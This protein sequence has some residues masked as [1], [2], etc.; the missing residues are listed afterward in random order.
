[1][2][3]L[4]RKIGV[5]SRYFV[6]NTQYTH[7][8]RC[9]CKILALPVLLLRVAALTVAVRAAARAATRAASGLLLSS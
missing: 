3:K 9:F 7:V 2:K 4:D 6:L 5:Q 8:Y 1:M